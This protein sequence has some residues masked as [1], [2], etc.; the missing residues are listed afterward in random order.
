MWNCI[1]YYCIGV[2][3]GYS[4]GLGLLDCLFALVVLLICGS[5]LFCVSASCGF[6]MLCLVD[7]NVWCVWLFNSVVACVF[8]CVWYVLI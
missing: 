6:G 7:V 5:V 1:I 4:G 3:F 2:W 8:F